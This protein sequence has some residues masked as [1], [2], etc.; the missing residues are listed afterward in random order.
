MNK[1]QKAI[2]YITL[3]VTNL[4]NMQNFYCA[5]GFELHTASDNPEH[6]YA[7]YKCGN[8]ILALYPRHLLTKQ[9]GCAVDGINQAVSIS[10]NVENKSDVDD[11][12]VMVKHQQSKITRDAFEPDWGGYCGYFQDPE[13]NLWEVVWNEKFIF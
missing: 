6:P 4:Q 8:I 13:G 10:L 2:S 11:F 7:M 5:L 3:G 1:N 12:L 9:S